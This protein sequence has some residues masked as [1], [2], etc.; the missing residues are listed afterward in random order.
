MS[1]GPARYFGFLVD[2]EEELHP[3]EVRLVYLAFTRPDLVA[4]FA[5]PGTEILYC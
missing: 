3:G 4:P 2:I 1:N 5:K